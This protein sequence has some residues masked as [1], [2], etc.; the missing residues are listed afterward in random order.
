MIEKSI[1]PKEIPSIAIIYLAIGKYDIF[2]EGFY[3]SCEQYLF[4]DAVKHYFVFT[5]SHKLLS[6]SYHNVSMIPVIDMGWAANTTAKSK[7]IISICDTLKAFD[8][9]FYINANYKVLTTILSKEI[10]PEK[11][12][13]YLTALSYYYLRESNCDTLPYDRNPDSL[14]YIPFGKGKYYYQGGFYGGRTTEVLLVSETICMDSQIDQD[15]GIMALWHDESYLN[16]YL[17]T[18]TPKIIGD[19]YCYPEECGIP[20]KAILVNKERILGVNEV[21]Q[22]KAA[23]TDPALEYL[24]EVPFKIQPLSLVQSH[25]DLGDQMFQYAFMLEQKELFPDKKYLLVN[26]SAGKEDC[27]LRDV[28][29]LPD[30]DFAQDEIIFKVRNTPEVYVHKIKESGNIFQNVQ[31]SW[32]LLTIYQGNWQTELYFKHIH[33]KIRKSFQ[34]DEAKVNERTRRLATRIKSGLSVGVYFKSGEYLDKGKINEDVCSHYYY[35]QAFKEIEKR[36]N[37]KFLHYYIFTDDPAWIQEN[38]HIKNFV[39]IDSVYGK[40]AWQ[41]MYLMSICN[42]NII[43]NESFCWWGAWLNSHNDKIVIAP[44]RWFSTKLA[45]DIHP[46]NWIR[47]PPSAHK[48]NQL[49]DDIENGRLHLDNNGLLYGKMGLVIFLFHFARLSKDGFYEYIAED[50]LETI[51]ANLNKETPLNY[52]DGLSGIGSAIEYLLQNEFIIGNPDDIFEEFDQSFNQAI[53]FPSED[54]SLETGMRGWIRY[55]EF[56]TSGPNLIRN[57]IRYQQNKQNLDSLQRH[58]INIDPKATKS[59][60]PV[61]WDNSIGLRGRSGKELAKL[62]PSI[63]R[64]LIY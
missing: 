35:M 52:A 21:N 7:Y 59:S 31:S 58:L 26:T 53:R 5:D 44:S 9:T 51:L 22:I 1:I 12:D 60:L 38:I 11:S 33:S 45:P 18:H 16:R 47:K 46:H 19:E 40:E 41:D 64:Q 48:H 13:G 24:R 62:K 4:T 30:K 56:R 17:L 55:F 20:G 39:I 2:W 37:P 61:S 43:A 23:Y 15:K 6:E 3:Q 50:I 57:S 14:A 42:H 29:N 8:Y 54:C 27:R 49:I 28:F 10:L 34:F 63:V 32:R 36:V 25:G